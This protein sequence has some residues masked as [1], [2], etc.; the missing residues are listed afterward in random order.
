VCRVGS[1]E[2]GE[3]AV[4]SMAKLHGFAWGESDGVVVEIGK[5]VIYN[6]SVSAISLRDHANR[7]HAELG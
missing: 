3:D 4:E 1:K 2:L 5:G 6:R 7:R